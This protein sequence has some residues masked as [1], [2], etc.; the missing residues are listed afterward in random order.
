MKQVRLWPINSLPTPFAAF[1][2]E[3]EDEQIEAEVDIDDNFPKGR[4]LKYFPNQKYG[5]VRDRVGREIY[6]H[7]Q[8]MDFVG[9]KGV[10]AL[11]AGIAVGYDLVH[12]GLRLHVKKMKIYG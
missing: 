8:E 10:D 12:S 1:V 3:A 6:F 9:S 2:T 7:L 11:K 4:V 5:F